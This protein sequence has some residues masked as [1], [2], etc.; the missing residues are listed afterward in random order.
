MCHTLQ[1]LKSWE[2]V[3]NQNISIKEKNYSWENVFY[4]GNYSFLHWIVKV[5]MICRVNRAR[6]R[7][8]CC[9][10]RRIWRRSRQFIR[11]RWQNKRQLTLRL[12]RAARTSPWSM[13]QED[14]RTCTGSLGAPAINW[15]CWSAQWAS[16]SWWGCLSASFTWKVSDLCAT[17]RKRFF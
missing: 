14:R 13:V 16:Y 6:H 1:H 8:R 11:P 5:N 2:V 10:R 12:L 9:W 15:L 7:A 3:I 4:I 17:M